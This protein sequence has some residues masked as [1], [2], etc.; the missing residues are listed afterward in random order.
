MT[1][2]RNKSVLHRVGFIMVFCLFETGTGSGG[3][4]L[5]DSCL[6]FFFFLHV[7][8]HRILHPCSLLILFKLKRIGVLA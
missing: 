5:H 2:N 4:K 6:T 7:N 3:H 8:A 1:I